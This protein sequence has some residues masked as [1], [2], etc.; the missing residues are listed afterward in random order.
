MHDVILGDALRLLQ[1]LE[2]PC[3][4]IVVA[5]NREDLFDGILDGVDLLEG[6][7]V[8]GHVLLVGML[9]SPNLLL[10]LLL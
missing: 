8:F 10:Q 2:F 4:L 9:I 6:L 7:L 5:D 1:H 3:G